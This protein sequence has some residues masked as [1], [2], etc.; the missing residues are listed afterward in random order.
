MGL[1]SRGTERSTSSGI[2]LV[3]PSAASVSAHSFP[4]SE[5]CPLT[6]LNLVGADLR[7][8]AYAAALNQDA[9]GTLVHPASSQLHSEWVMVVITYCESVT[10]V[11]S[12]FRGTD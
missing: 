12:V 11:R 5:L 10:M 1:E 9:F 8:I 4:Q 6:H 3:A 2:D 7:C